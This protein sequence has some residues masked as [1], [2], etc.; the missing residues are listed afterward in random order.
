MYKLTILLFILFFACNIDSYAQS[1][2]TV[3]QLEQVVISEN[4]LSLPLSEQTRSIIV[5]DQKQLSTLPSQSVAGALQY[6]AGIDIRQR[7]PNGVQADAGIRGS[8]FDQVLILVN[9]I[10]ISDLQTGHHSLNLPVDIENIER[11]EVLK[12]PG[13][14]VFGQNAFAGAINIITKNP[15]Q[16]FFKIQASGGQHSLWGAK[17]SGSFKTGSI[18]HYLS[19][20][21]DHSDGYKY[22]TDYDI[23]NH[24]YQADIKSG[25]NRLQL[26]GGLTSRK[27]GANGFYA[28]PAF[29]DQYEEIQTSLAAL[30]IARP[31]NNSV[32]LKSSVYWRRNRDDYVFVRENP[33]AY[34]NIHTSNNYGADLNLSISN[35]LGISG[36]GLDVNQLE[37][38][39]N[40]L[41]QRSRSVAT[42]FVEHRFEWLD[43]KLSLTPGFQMNYYSDFDLNVLPGIDMG[44]DLSENI[45]LYANWG[46]TYR[47]PTFTDLY[48]SDQANRGNPD[49]QP[50][51]ANTYEIG[52]KTIHLDGW[53]GQMAFFHRQSNDIIDW[54]KA[55]AADPWTPDNLIGVNTSGI[56]GNLTWSN[57]S[58]RTV[59]QRVDVGY[60]YIQA[61]TVDVEEGGFSRYALENLKHQ[62]SVGVSLRYS[63]Y[64]S[65]MVYFRHY[66]RVNLDDYQLVDT[67]LNFHWEKITAFVEATNLFDKTYKETNLVTMPGRWLK[68]GVGY[69]F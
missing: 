60:T 62:L 17:A 49:L 48:Y 55:D 51:F 5:I 67:R 34:Q 37:L 11:I 22:N 9:G 7:G 53:N 15:D 10:K 57:I 58:Q 25:K 61:T 16:P 44:Y 50:E 46:R 1:D 14:R 3:Q 35:K 59:I 32:F 20:S 38:E 26:M 43:K 24:F 6:F 52:L 13:A 68:S 12:G 39:S 33:S 18:K 42:L 2:T 29:M 4:R 31:L 36:I 64:F 63:Q 40:N 66:D 19:T 23:A 8:T 45:G 41:G 28:S 47:V 69:T 65:Q 27:F 56:D 30:K 54:S 21:F